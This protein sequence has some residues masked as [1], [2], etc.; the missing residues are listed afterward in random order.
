[1]TKIIRVTPAGDVIDVPGNDLLLTARLALGGSVDT[2]TCLMPD[3]APPEYP[4]W[5]GLLIGCTAEF[6]RVEEGAVVNP[7]A[8]ALYGR[9]PVVG[10]IYFAADVDDSDRDWHPPDLDP[11][12][13][14]VLRTDFVRPGIM[15]VEHM[16]RLARNAGHIWPGVMS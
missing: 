9:S 15:S 7:K 1:M 11:E 14:A 16:K 6:G 2:F 5:Q 10:D 3:G 4:H 8:W 12:F 13:L